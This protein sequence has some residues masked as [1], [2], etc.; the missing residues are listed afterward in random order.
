VAEAVIDIG[1]ET[2]S[3]LVATTDA[4]RIKPVWERRYPMLASVAGARSLAEFVAREGLAAR[5]AGAET[6]HVLLAPELR[7]GQM[8]RNLARRLQALG[9]GPLRSL[10]TAERSRL[11]FLGATACLAADPT[12]AAPEK[13]TAVI[14]LGDAFTSLAVGLPG[15]SPDWIASRPLNARHLTK[16]VM[17]SDPPPL[18]EQIAAADTARRQLSNLMPPA[19]ETVLVTGADAGLLALVFGETIDT[20]SCAVVRRAIDGRLSE[21]VSAQFEIDLLA[22]RRLPGLLAI[23]EAFTELLGRPLKVVHGGHAEGVLLHDRQEVEA[24]DIV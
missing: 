20:R 22:A 9:F 21:I 7:A 3:V 10:T 24:G 23:V 2:T 6:L 14:D 15:K 1:S 18:H 13:R 4:G 17:P 16:S 12:T 19:V 8:S 5:E 11:C